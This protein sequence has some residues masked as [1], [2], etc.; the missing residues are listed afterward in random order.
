MPLALNDEC[1]A[2]DRHQKAVEKR[3]KLPQA[4]PQRQ[5]TVGPAMTSAPPHILRF[6]GYTLDSARRSLSRDGELVTLRP[7]AMEVLCHLALRAGRPVSKAELFGAVWPGI[8]VTDDSLVQCV[9]DIRRALRDR[10]RRIVKTVPRVGYLFAG[11][12]STTDDEG[13]THLPHKSRP[14]SSS[15]MPL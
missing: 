7:Q 5:T 15:A 11:L 4:V 10:H 14:A 12:V 6:E 8:S 13:L 2:R 9:R 3:R 1:R